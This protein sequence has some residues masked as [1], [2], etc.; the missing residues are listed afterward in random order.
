MYILTIVNILYGKLLNFLYFSIKDLGKHHVMLFMKGNLNMQDL[1]VVMD[2]IPI[3]L[4]LIDDGQLPMRF[5]YC[6]RL[7][8]AADTSLLIRERCLLSMERT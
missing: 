4:T 8:M 6:C 3:E 7:F 2:T 1:P 5:R